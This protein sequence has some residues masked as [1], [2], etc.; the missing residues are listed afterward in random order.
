MEIR[1]LSLITRDNFLNG[2][3][4][5]AFPTFMT[6]NGDQAHIYLGEENSTGNNYLCILGGSKKMD[7]LIK[8]SGTRYDI[9]AEDSMKFYNIPKE[10]LEKGFTVEV[11]EYEQI[12]EYNHRSKKAN[13]EIRNRLIVKHL[14]EKDP[15]ITFHFIDGPFIE[16]KDAGDKEFLVEFIDTETNKTEYS[17]TIK[18]NTWSRCYIRYFKKWLIK[19]TEINSDKVYSHRLDLKGKNVLISLGSS[20]L[21]DTLAWFPHIEEFAKK[22]ECKVYVSTFKNSLFENNYRDLIFVNPGVVINNIYASYEIGWFYDDDR[23]DGGKNP[24]DFKDI[25][26]QA[27]TTDI[28][29]LEHSDLRPRL[30]IPDLGRK[31]EEPYVCIGMHSTAQA[32]YWNNPT[33][34]QEVT[35]WFISKGYKVV[36]LSLEE[37]G[38][39]GNYY[40]KGVIGVEGEKTLANAMNYL[41]YSHMFIGI[42]S[43]LSWLSWSVGTPTV[44]IS[45]FSSPITEPT[46][47]NVIRIFNSKSCTSCFN[48]YRLDAGDWN[49]CP[50]QKGTDRQFECTKSIT[51]E[52]VINEI[53]KYFKLGFSKV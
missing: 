2:F 28:L 29:G 6:K 17:T 26:L 15:T 31:I 43:G 25:P 33:G 16:I 52:H 18:N 9:E 1:D 45:G 4:A 51:G 44:I 32:K 8:T 49:W 10:I 21:G 39:M 37:D 46:T 34:W 5:P 53:D 24:R 7:V 19:A 42:G 30:V 47:E 38:Y 13:V 22:H 11:P 23:F 14:E 35:D 20:S 3:M 40:P 12:Y 41:K 50:D 36:M 27:T 48:R